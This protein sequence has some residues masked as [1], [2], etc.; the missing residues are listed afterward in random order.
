MRL[1]YSPTPPSGADAIREPV[2]PTPGTPT[3]RRIQRPPVCAG[4]YWLLAVYLVHETDAKHFREE[5]RHRHLDRCGHL[6]NWRDD[7]RPLR[8]GQ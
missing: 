6:Y 8:C 3:A 7:L 4:T 5:S 2:D 1:A